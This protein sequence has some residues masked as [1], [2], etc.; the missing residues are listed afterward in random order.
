MR[1]PR[2][3]ALI[4]LFTMLLA[5]CGAAA[6]ETTTTS[7]AT[8]T[9]APEETPP[10]EASDAP[11]WEQ[12]FPGDAP[13]GTV[14]LPILGGIEFVTTEPHFV[15]PFPMGEP[16][17]ISLELMNDLNGWVDIFG[18]P[19]A[20]PDEV[21]AVLSE[22]DMTL[23]E[24]EDVDNLAFPAQAVDYDEAP[25][26]VENPVIGTWFPANAGRIWMVDTERGTLVVTASASDEA[27]VDRP[28]TI[29]RTIAVAEQILG[30]M[31]LVDLP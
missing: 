3:L 11:S 13:A 2:F 8:T 22:V 20:T 16:F 17:S 9:T 14:R 18:Q 5:G 31:S 21:L 26:D 6:D 28:E 4:A 29:A 7:Q 24:V 27:G 30:T 19:D 10:D 23:G 1:K 25:Y 15:A 12:G